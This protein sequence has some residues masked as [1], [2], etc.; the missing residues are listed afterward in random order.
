MPLGRSLKYVS[1]LRVKLGT[2]GYPREIN[3]GPRVDY[4]SRLRWDVNRLLSNCQNSY[5]ALRLKEINRPGIS[6]QSL[7]LAQCKGKL[8]KEEVESVDDCIIY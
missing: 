4:H 5:L 8:G 1:S 6:P 2:D 7:R 3:L